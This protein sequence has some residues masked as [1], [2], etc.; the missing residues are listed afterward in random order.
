LTVLMS[1]MGV[2]KY[3][4]LGAMTIDLSTGLSTGSSLS[5]SQQ[6]LFR[7]LSKHFQTIGS[8]LSA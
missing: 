5:T 6:K 3:K 4:M 7:G 2:P 8:K 1:V